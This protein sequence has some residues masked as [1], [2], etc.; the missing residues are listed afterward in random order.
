MDQERFGQ[1]SRA[2]GRAGSRRAALAAL[3]GA[4][5]AAVPG[6]ARA[7]EVGG[8][9]NIIKGCRLP[10]QRCRKGSNCCTNR[11]GGDQRCRCVN[12]KGSCLVDMGGGIT[13]P[14][15]A[16]CCSNKCDDKSGQCR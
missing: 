10:G 6:L 4:A 9:S 11:C 14:V 8:Q 13:L 16:V 12:K 1:I 5:L 3:A 7:G 2:V 15:H